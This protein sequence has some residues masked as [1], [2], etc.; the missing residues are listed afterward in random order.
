MKSQMEQSQKMNLYES[1]IN[2][3]SQKLS[4]LDELTLLQRKNTNIVQ[5]ISE[6]VASILQNNMKKAFEE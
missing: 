1:Q 4:Q 3:Y 6:E 5:A 2:N